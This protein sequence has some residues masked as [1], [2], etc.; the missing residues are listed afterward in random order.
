MADIKEM[1]ESVEAQFSD[2]NGLHPGLWPLVPRMIAAVGVFVLTIVIGWFFYWSDQMSEIDLGQ[3]EEQKLKDSY[4]TK[5][6]Q[7]ISL[8]ALKEQKKLVDQYVLRMEKQLPSSA[9]M[10]ALL[11]DINSAA[12]GRGLS[13]DLFK[14]GDVAVKDYYAEQPIIIQ[15]VANYNDLGAFVSDIAKL[16]RIITLHNLNFSVSKDAKKPGIVL[17]GIA[18]TYRYLDPEEVAAV[19]EQKKKDKEKG[20]KK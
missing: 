10:G 9:E 13:F 3:Q 5:M 4:K 14:P 20:A 16:P 6:Q 18:K 17:D 1:I 8:D 2:L 12:N 15:M 11:E 7:S 19:Q